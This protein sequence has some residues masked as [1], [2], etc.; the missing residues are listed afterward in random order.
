MEAQYYRTTVIVQGR[1]RLPNAQYHHTKCLSVYHIVNGI[2]ILCI[3]IIIATL[4]Y[5]VTVKKATLDSCFW[6][7]KMYWKMS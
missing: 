2:V 1:L 6:N 5:T 7:F 4:I 3:M